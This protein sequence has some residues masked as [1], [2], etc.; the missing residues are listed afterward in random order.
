MAQRMKMDEREITERSGENDRFL[1]DVNQL[2]D[3]QDWRG[4][5]CYLERIKCIE[6]RVYICY[7][8]LAL[9]SMDKLAKEQGKLRIVHDKKRYLREKK[10]N[11]RK[12][13]LYAKDMNDEHSHVEGLDD[14]I[15]IVP[16]DNILKR[17]LGY[18]VRGF[19]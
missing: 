8:A 13:I 1:D 3:K 11:P 18:L 16:S 14:M 10:K 17:Y 2:V 15:E 12:L 9:Y 19:N 5:V 6:K 4:A 7:M